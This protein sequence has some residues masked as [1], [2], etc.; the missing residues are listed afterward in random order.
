MFQSGIEFGRERLKSLLL[1]IRAVAPEF[2]VAEGPRAA[3]T[4]RGSLAPFISE[5]RSQR[6]SDF[7]YIDHYSGDSIILIDPSSTLD[8]VSAWLGAAC[9]SVK[10][11]STLQSASSIILQTGKVGLLVLDL[12]GCGGIAKIA[13]TLLK[14]RKEY[15][16]IPVIMIDNE[17]FGD[18]FSVERLAL[19][20]VTLRT[21]ISLPR[22]DLA[23]AESQVN[24][25]VWQDRLRS[26]SAR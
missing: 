14:F 7:C 20:D 24:N 11:I 17:G 1:G 25:Q 15:P 2:A 13:T 22:L 10:R 26:M 12:E 16:E 23:M 4:A 21:P 6:F 18:D 9:T 19:A 5:H 8:D 3:S